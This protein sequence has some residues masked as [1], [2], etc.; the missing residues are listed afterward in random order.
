MHTAPRPCACVNGTVPRSTNLHYRQLT[1]ALA[2]TG[3]GFCVSAPAQLDHLGAFARD[4]IGP[5]RHHDPPLI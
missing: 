3:G 2:V 4:V 5:L 1:P